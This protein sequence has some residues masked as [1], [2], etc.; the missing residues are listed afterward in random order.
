MNN[1]TAVTCQHQHVY[2]NEAQ[3]WTRL[4]HI[5]AVR[6]RHREQHTHADAN[7]D[8]GKCRHAGPWCLSARRRRWHQ[9]GCVTTPADGPPSS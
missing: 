2:V 5:G 4:L 8:Q 9:L 7:K 1:T 6:A 3:T